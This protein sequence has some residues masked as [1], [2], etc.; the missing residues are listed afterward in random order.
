M[1]TVDSG[2]YSIEE[3]SG[4]RW[5]FTGEFPSSLVARCYEYRKLPINELNAGHL[6]LLVSQ[7][8]GLGYIMP[9]ILDH[10]K[11]DPTVEGSYYP[12]DLLLA[13]ANIDTDYWKENSAQLQN[14]IS[15]VLNQRSAITGTLSSKRLDQILTKLQDF[16]DD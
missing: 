8:I 15:I 5:N 13:V 9:S 14:L 1:K 16:S 12:G 4:E 6:R 2:R 3:L 7:G 11:A 10:L